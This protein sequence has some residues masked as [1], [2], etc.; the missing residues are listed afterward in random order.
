M[1]IKCGVS[2]SV[3]VILLTHFIALKSKDVRFSRSSQEENLFSH[4]LLLLLTCFR[5]LAPYGQKQH[6]GYSLMAL[7]GFYFYSAVEETFAQFTGSPKYSLKSL[8]LS[9]LRRNMERKQ[10]VSGK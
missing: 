2:A 9:V 5:F 3:T 10:P 7:A 4:N 6:S 8:V 1:K